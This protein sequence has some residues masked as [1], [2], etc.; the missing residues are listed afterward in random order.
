MTRLSVKTDDEG[1]L[2]QLGQA[3]RTARSE[4]GLSQES[5]ADAAGLDRSHMGKVERGERNLSVLNLLRVA[6]ALDMTAANLLA[7]AKL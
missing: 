2:V 3:I 4:R 5:F 1:K 7:S 6:N